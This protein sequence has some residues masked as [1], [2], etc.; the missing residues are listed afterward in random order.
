MKKDAILLNVGRGDTVV[1]NDL[2]Y[3]LEKGYIN[4]AGLDVTDP[5]PLPQ[6][7]PLWNME[8][9][10]ITPHVSGGSFEHLEETYQNI[11]EICIKNLI[12]YRKNESLEHIVNL[13]EGY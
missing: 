9:V 2:V 6:S 7:H 10:I 8:Q 5:E 11:I 13:K 1:T 12:H 3:A 4:G